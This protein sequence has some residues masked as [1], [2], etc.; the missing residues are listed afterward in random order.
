M[1]AVSNILRD[2]P[3]EEAY[4]LLE[5]LCGLKRTD[6]L[7]GKYKDINDDKK[8]L[9][10]DAAR[11]RLQGEPIQYITGSWPFMGESFYVGQGVLIPRDDTEVLVRAADKLIKEHALRYCTDL[12]AGTGIIGITLKKLNKNLNVTAVEKY[13]DAYEYLIKNCRRLDAG[14]KT[15]CA[16]LYDFHNT[17][18]NNSLDIL[19][20]NP[21]YIRSDVIPTL[22][23]EI[24]YEPDTALDGGYD[25]L[26]FYKD[27]INIYT[28]KI[29][30]GGFIAFEIGEDQETDI[31]SLLK[32][33]YTDI[34]VYRDIQNLPR[35][36]TA[37]KFCS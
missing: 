35:A 31:K 15:V 6:I 12:C 33:R 36:V 2:L 5:D 34:K 9:L 7:L 25:G 8:T 23:K 17:V 24:E 14:I 22:Q 1:D 3:K 16:D 26:K 4:I 21:P 30:T 29:K 13:S 32:D 28:D 20:S 18:E 10:I 19:V 27:I 37:R 11:R